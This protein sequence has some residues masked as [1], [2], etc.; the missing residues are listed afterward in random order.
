MRRGRDSKAAG[1]G[2]LIAAYG[3]AAALTLSKPLTIISMGA[4]FAA[5]GPP[6]GSR[7]FVDAAVLV[8]GIFAGITLWFTLL[9]FL[10]DRARHRLRSRT[11]FWINRG[12][13]IALFALGIIALFA[14]V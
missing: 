13:G 4:M 11:L 2:G 7:P 6:V 5:F 3:A 1:A 8:A 10:I 12:A 14:V 9:A